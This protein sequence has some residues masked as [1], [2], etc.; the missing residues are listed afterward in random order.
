MT[1]IDRLP[2]LDGRLGWVEILPDGQAPLGPVLDGHHRADIAIIGAG[3]AGVALAHRLAELRPG[4]RILLVDALRV[5]QGASGRNAG[6]I[7]DLPHTVD[8]VAGDPDRDRALHALNSGAIGWLDAMRHRHGIDCG[9]ERAGKYLAAHEPRHLPRLRSF[10]EGLLRAD[11]DAEW[12]E[13]EALARRLGTGFYR[14]AVFSRGNILVNP[15][16]LV[17]GLARALPSSVALFEASPVTGIEPGSPHRLVTPRGRIEADIVVAATGAWAK[18]FGAERHVVPVF[19]YASLTGPLRPDTLAGVRPWGLTSAHPAGATLRLTPDRRLFVRNTFRLEPGLQ[20]GPAALARAVRQHRRAF[21]ARFPAL[22][23]L[24]FDHSW[25][26]MIGVTRGHAP[27]LAETLPGLFTLSGCN[28]VGVAKGVWLGQHL[29]EWIWGQPSAELA[30]VRD[31]ARPRA[32]PP[33]VLTQAAARLRLA[34][35]VALAGQDA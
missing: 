25:G 4:A 19:T 22:A 11:F 7:I 17:R 18:A 6:F 31:W 8:A 34:F 21:D 28:G 35:E 32:L 2:A 23:G 29:A 16:A 12:L 20:S 9:W 24:R 10:A 14:A 1:A 3:F 27:V 5:G 15:A 33:E 13:G 26:G 30:L